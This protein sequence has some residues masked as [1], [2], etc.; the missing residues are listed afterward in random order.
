MKYILDGYNVIGAM[1]SIGLGDK[2]KESK[3]VAWLQ[4]YRQGAD[5]VVLIFDGQNTFVDFPTTERLPGITVIHTAISRSAD[6]YIKQKILT[7]KDTSHIVVVT[8]DNDILY[9]AKKAKVKTMA[10]PAFLAFWTRDK[11]GV[12]PKRSPQITD[13]HVDFWLDEFDG[14]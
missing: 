6:D 14:G 12:P 11:S 4:R 7:K 13:K 2:D 9:A 10:S 8:S 3:C 5:Q 1:D